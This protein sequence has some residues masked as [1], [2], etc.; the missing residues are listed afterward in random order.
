MSKEVRKNNFLQLW[1]VSCHLC[2]NL[3]GYNILA[4]ISDHGTTVPLS[5][6]IYVSDEIFTAHSL[7]VVLAINPKRATS[8][9]HV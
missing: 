9:K 8:S 4:S 2:I 1:L 7:Y 5:V 3:L 6:Q